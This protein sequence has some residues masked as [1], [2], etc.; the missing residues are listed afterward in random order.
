LPSRGKS[1][2]PSM[3][4]CG[5]KVT[6]I[7]GQLYSSMYS[8]CTC[9]KSCLAKWLSFWDFC[10]AYLQVCLAEVLYSSS[11]CRPLVTVLLSISSGTDFYEV[12]VVS[13]AI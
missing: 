7:M 3:F 1:A 2:C 13:S 4:Y 10:C 8:D 12:S 5:L 6:S 9:F 11:I